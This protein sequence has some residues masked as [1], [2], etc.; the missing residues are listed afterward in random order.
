MSKQTQDTWTRRRMLAVAGAGAV[1]GLAGCADESSEEPEEEPEEAP[2]EDPEEDPEEEPEALAHDEPA[3]FPEGEECAVCNMVTPEY[4]E[5]NAQVVHENG[6]R[7]YF[8]SSGCLSAY[9]ADPEH[10]DGPGS[11]IENAWVTCYESGE[12]I[13]GKE[14]YYVRVTDSDHVDDPMMRNPTPFGMREDAEAFADEFDEYDDSDI[15]T[16][17]DFD[18]DLAEFYRGNFFA[19]EDMDDHDHD[20]MDHDHDDME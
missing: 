13:D 12:L 19:D 9:V 8:C 16:Y 15:I 5:W 20:D 6:D 11:D 2:E 14:A 10:F 3:E 1:V 17:G 4:P 18:Q 7:A